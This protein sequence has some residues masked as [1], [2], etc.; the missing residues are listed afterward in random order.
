S[1]LAAILTGMA[2]RAPGL[3]IALYSEP[4]LAP[5]WG[6]PMPPIGIASLDA[7]ITLGGDGTLL[8][9]ARLLAG[10]E[11]PVMGINLGRGGFRTACGRSDLDTALAR[12]AAK[13]FVTEPR[14]TLDGEIA[15]ATGSRLTLPP[16][17]NDV[18][19]HKAGVARLIQLDVQVDGQ[20]VGPYSADGLIVA[21]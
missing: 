20:Q 12:L 16:A 3:G 15:T 11:V 13:D 21:T 10:R 9:G 14:L 17:L 18:A 2:A 1:G 8:R 6:R 7:L 5:L 19:I 4:E